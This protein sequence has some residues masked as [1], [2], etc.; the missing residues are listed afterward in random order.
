M[1][2]TV[3][4]FSDE[5]REAMPKRIERVLKSCCDAM[6]ASYSYEYL[7]RYPVTSN[8]PDQTRYA[9][10][11]AENTFDAERVITA[12][13]LMGAEDFSFFAQRVPACFYT[14][15][16]QGGAST[17]IPHHSSTFDIDE[18]A[19]PTGVAMMAALAFDAPCNA[20]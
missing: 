9:R 6:G 8:D 16:C 3:R 14:V 13:K 15:G 2:G 17:A 10:A 1:L 20:P 12:D 7:W 18:R 4:A 5:V 11:L 19:L